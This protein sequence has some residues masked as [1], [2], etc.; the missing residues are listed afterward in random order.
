MDTTQL[1]TAETPRGDDTEESR[2]PVARRR[3]GRRVGILSTAVVVIVATLGLTSGAASAASFFTPT[4]DC[5]DS[6]VKIDPGVRS[7]NGTTDG[8]YRINLY[9]YSNG[10]RHIRS[11][12]GRTSYNQTA[13]PGRVSFG[14]VGSGYFAAS[15]ERWNAQNGRWVAMP[16][17]LAQTTDPY[18]QRPT[19][20][21]VCRL[22]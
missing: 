19:G 18:F 17:S 5:V 14:G 3:R 12:A 13:V 4:L 7:W 15:V 20:V 1:E 16:L 21:I 22:Y 9:K 11:Y 6:S 10:W 2:A 8:L